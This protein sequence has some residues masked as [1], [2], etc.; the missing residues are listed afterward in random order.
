MKTCSD[1]LHLFLKNFWNQV[2]FQSAY[3]ASNVD[4]IVESF[5][6]KFNVQKQTILN[7]W[8]L[9]KILK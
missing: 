8:K 9:K 5:A 1:L 4:S 2:A 3:S 7:Q 6:G